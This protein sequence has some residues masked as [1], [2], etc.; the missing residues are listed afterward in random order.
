[1]N[2]LLNAAVTASLAFTC[3]SNAAQAEVLVIDGM[4]PADSSAFAQIQ[5]IA[6]EDFGG[7]D[8]R[9][10]AF[11]LE[12]A[13]A[14]IRIY[15]EP[16][17][18]VI[19]GRSAV[20]SDAILS[21]NVTTDVE[22]D[23]TVAKRRRCVERD[24]KDKCITHKN[25]RVDCLTRTVNFRAELRATRYSDGRRI[26][27]ESFPNQNEQTI[28]FGDDEEFTSRRSIIRNMVSE[29]VGTIRRDLAPR[30]YRREV[31]V[32]ESRKGM[33]KADGKFFKAAVKMTKSNPTEACRMWD[34][35]ADN[36]LVHI[37]LTFN[38]GLCAEQRG[39]F[40]SAIAL[41]QEA[42]RISPGK[43]EV[44]QSIQRIS[45]HRRALDEWELRQSGTP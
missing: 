25:I 2:R 14:A 9:A 20:E 12:D 15:G 22:Q 32:L 17:F 40:E 7:R 6:L 42:Q 34:E 37:S 13:L 21:G 1:M 45:D 30:Q 4:T 39:D 35:A 38:R 33:A 41:Y 28:C 11:E 16:Y 23:E 3:L 31:R 44:N 36:G 5:S 43:L 29:T 19:G 8:G 27:S 26:Y 18:D 24:D 10:L